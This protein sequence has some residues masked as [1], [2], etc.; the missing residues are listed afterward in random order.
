MEDNMWRYNSYQYKIQWLFGVRGNF[1]ESSAVQ[2]K[3][4]KRF[5]FA[6][7]ARAL[8]GIIFRDKDYAV[9]ETYDGYTMYDNPEADKNA[10]KVI[11]KKLR[12]N[13]KITAVELLRT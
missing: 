11:L 9:I 7:G 13:D 8:D 4:L 1:I 10:W 6:I 2:K 3:N 5:L 12:E